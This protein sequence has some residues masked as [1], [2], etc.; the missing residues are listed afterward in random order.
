MD[1]VCRILCWNPPGLNDYQM[2]KV[3]HMIC[4]IKHNKRGEAEHPDLFLI[5]Y[6]RI[7]ALSTIF[8]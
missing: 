3:R 2:H 1:T 8:C 7:D 5:E 6:K 4:A